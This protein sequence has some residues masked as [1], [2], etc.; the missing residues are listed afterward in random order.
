MATYIENIDKTFYEETGLRLQNVSYLRLFNLV[1]DKQNNVKFLN[2]FKTFIIDQENANKY[3]FEI[4]NVDNDDWFDNISSRYYGT[5]YL[6]WLIALMNN[7]TNPFEEL[8]PGMQLKMLKKDY[9]YVVIKEIA[10]ISRL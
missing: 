7:I 2:I 5:P 8:N 6:W 1:Y 4:Y 10:D 9:I 3:M